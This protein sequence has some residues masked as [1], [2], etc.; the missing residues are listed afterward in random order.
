MTESQT[1]RREWRAPVTLKFFNAQRRRLVSLAYRM[2]GSRAEA[3]DV[4]QDAW[5]KWHTSDSAA[6]REPA[7]WLTTVVTRLSIDR[8]REIQTE[9]A[10]CESGSL[11]ELWTDAVVPSVEHQVLDGAQLSYGLMLLMDK[12][13]PDERAAFLLREAF[14]CDYATI[15]EAIGK[16]TDHCRQLIRRAKTRLA[17]AGAPLKLADAVA[18]RHIVGR[19]RD[20]IAA[21]D[22]AALLDLLDGAQVIGDTSEP[23]LAVAH[24]EAASIGADAALV[25]FEDGDI[26]ELW[27]PCYNARGDLA[28]YVVK[29]KD[30]L[31]VVNRVYGRA[32]I[33]R[34]L[35]RVG[36]SRGVPTIA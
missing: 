29:Q 23:A 5:L 9:R 6:L 8:L 18:Q 33:A 32:A 20:A 36:D 30:T 34:M 3:E 2:L 22:H 15:G 28:F 16:Q 31:A 21:Q 1:P 10:A 24:A 26:A 4:V 35:A 11:P 25:F 14:D 13:S 7:A 19:L 12:L 27:V 17:R